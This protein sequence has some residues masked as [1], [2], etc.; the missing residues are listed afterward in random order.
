MDLC[1][2]T[3]VEFFGSVAH[4]E[5]VWRAIHS[6]HFFYACVYKVSSLIRSINP[7]NCSACP[8][9]S[10]FRQTHHYQSLMF[11]FSGCRCSF[12]G[13]FSF[14]LLI[15]RLWYMVNVHVCTISMATPMQIVPQKFSLCNL[16][17]LPIHESFLF[18]KFLAIQYN[19]YI[20]Y[21]VY[22]I[23]LEQSPKASNSHR[24]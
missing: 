19:A 5:G 14:I 12:A 3:E 10:T 21:I 24:N 1:S 18:R 17:F 22:I 13:S 9:S 15:S 2:A 16:H 11:S 7:Y 20:N 4:M 23:D 6:R 8:C